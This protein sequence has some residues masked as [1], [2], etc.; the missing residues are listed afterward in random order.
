MNC[1]IAF[2]ESV[3]FKCLPSFS[4]ITCFVSFIFSARLHGTDC[5]LILSLF[6]SFRFLFSVSNLMSRRRSAGRS[7]SARQAALLRF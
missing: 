3:L 4:F 7:C 2:G 6:V 5:M 1:K